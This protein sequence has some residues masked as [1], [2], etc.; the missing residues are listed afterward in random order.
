MGLT[1]IIVLIILGILLILLEFF[2]VPGVTVAGI[3][4]LALLIV[5]IYFSYA[6][7]GYTMG[8]IILISVFASIAILFFI[9]H[10][11]GAWKAITL[12]TEVTGFSKTDVNISVKVGDKGKSISRLAPMGKIMIDKKIYE[13]GTTGTFIDEDIEIE[14]IRIKNNK[15]IVKQI[16]QTN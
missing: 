8:S 14:I 9:A 15:I 4:G 12:N 10:K 1:T 16:K 7:Y 3:G 6:N 5:S 11:T 2:V 13:A